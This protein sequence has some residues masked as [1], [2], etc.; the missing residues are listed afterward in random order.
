MSLPGRCPARPAIHREGLVEDVEVKSCLRQSDH[1]M[2]EFS[3]LGEV[4]RGQAKLLPWTSGGQNLNC[5][6]CW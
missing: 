1:K 3:N 4:R 6:G 2:V 5:S